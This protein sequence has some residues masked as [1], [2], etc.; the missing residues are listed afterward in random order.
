MNAVRTA[1]TGGPAM[2]F[3]AARLPRRHGVKGTRDKW[4][5]HT[6]LQQSRW[7][8]LLVHSVLQDVRL[9]ENG[10]PLSLRVS[11]SCGGTP[12]H[13]IPA[14]PASL[15]AEP[16]APNAVATNRV[17]CMRHPR[18]HGRWPG[19]FGHPVCERSRH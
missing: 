9:Y 18:L 16:G 7:Q 3:L 8:L 1:A 12:H 17:C 19:P 14:G 11:E 15:R 5:I 4:F 10:I 2:F 13:R 6:S